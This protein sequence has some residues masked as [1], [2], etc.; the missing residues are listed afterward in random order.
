MSLGAW[1]RANLTTQGYC[2]ADEERRELAIG[3]RFSTGLCLVLVVVALVL[4]SAAML[5]A[6]CGVALIAG[7]TARHPFDYLWNHVVRRASGAPPLPPNPARRRDAFKFGT[8]WLAV[9]GTLF[10]VGAMTAALVLGGCS[11]PPA[12]RSPPSTSACPRRRSP[13]G[14]GEPVA[15]RRPTHARRREAIHA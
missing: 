5:F 7:F 2:L 14:S 9:V 15:G 11:S 8:V 3:L 10:A 13:C 6:L 4:Q 12:R 1:T